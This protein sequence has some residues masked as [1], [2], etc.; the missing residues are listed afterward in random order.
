M[1]KTL[2]TFQDNFREGLGNV[3]FYDGIQN[4][5]RVDNLGNPKLY[6]KVVDQVLLSPTVMTRSMFGAKAF[7]GKVMDIDLDV[8]AD[9]QGQWVT[10]LEELN[11]SAVSTTVRTSFAHAAFTQPQVSIMLEAFANTGSLGVINLDT[12][13]YEKAAAQV[14]QAIGSA[15]YGQ[16]TGNQIL[17]LEAI[18]DNGT[19]N[20][21][22][23]GISRST[24]PQL[25]AYLA[26]VT[27]NKLT[28]ALLDT[29]HDNIRAA[30]LTNEKP[31]VAYTTKSIWSL[32][33]Q[34]LQPFVRQSYREV[35]YDKLTNSDK[36]GQRSNA[37]LRASA[38]FDGL[39]YRT[40][41]MIDDDFA[42]SG[43]IYMANEEYLNW[44][45]R[46]EV[47]DEYRD[48][49]EHVSFGDDST[50][51]G[52]GAL[53]ASAMPSTNHGFFY[54]APQQ[55]PTQGGKYARFWTIGN[56]MAS[57]YRRHGV[58]LG[59]TLITTI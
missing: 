49:I 28:L 14:V 57:S 42:T 38:G 54:Q 11:M 39:T 44:Y 35:G 37:L 50:Y 40:L 58:N 3:R 5:A 21:T 56:Y 41:T 8:V 9:T 48:T 36:F 51:E 32:Y 29:M 4:S 19:N 16:A 17:G 52:T 43:K 27:S 55:M 59:T 20:A 12:F 33:G 10:G 31:N 13:K 26:T 30:G 34:L 22:I 25:N 24:Y 46:S 45:G 7:E 15:A 2:H 6:T 18:I 47:P 23:G 53:A 1:I